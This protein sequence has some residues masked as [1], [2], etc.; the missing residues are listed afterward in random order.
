MPDDFLTKR[1]FDGFASS[2]RGEIQRLGELVTQ[3]N[4]KIDTLVNGRIDEARVMG[5]ITGQIRAILDRLEK[6]DKEVNELRTI[7][8]TVKERESER[9]NGDKQV[10]LNGW[11]TLAIGVII[12]IITGYFARK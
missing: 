2:F 7:I 9:Q 8:E 1:E 11:T 3:T 10:R 4:A 5:E 12:A 6:H